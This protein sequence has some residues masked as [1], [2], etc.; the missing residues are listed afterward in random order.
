MLS[1][2]QDPRYYPLLS[3]LSAA[4]GRENC[5]NCIPHCTGAQPR[6]SFRPRLQK[7]EKIKGGECQIGPIQ[8]GVK[9]DIEEGREGREEGRLIGGIRMDAKKSWNDQVANPSSH[10][11]LLPRR[12]DGRRCIVIHVALLHAPNNGCTDFGASELPR[13]QGGS[14]SFPF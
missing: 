6:I 10:V 8:G 4:A 9:R 3:V 14:W 11:R 2:E 12:R 7:E 1:S 13:A 5:V